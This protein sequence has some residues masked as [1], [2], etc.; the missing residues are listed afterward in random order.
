MTPGIGFPQAARA[1]QLP[2]CYKVKSSTLTGWT[3]VTLHI[4][5]LSLND[6]GHGS[7]VTRRKHLYAELTPPRGVNLARS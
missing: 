1:V 6:A 7:S 5:L 2:G 3:F 4:W